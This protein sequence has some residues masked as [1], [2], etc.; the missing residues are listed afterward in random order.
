MTTIAA[1]RSFDVMAVGQVA[2]GAHV[3][4]T[5]GD[6]TWSTSGLFNITALSGPEDLSVNGSNIPVAGTVNAIAA[7]DTN[8]GVLSYTVTGLNT[9]ITSLFDGVGFDPATS[10]ERYW[11]SI[12]AGTTD[13]TA[14]PDGD[15]SMVGDFI[16]VTAGQTVTGAADTFTVNQTFSALVTDLYGDAD[17]VQTAAT[18]TGGNDVINFSNTSGI[19]PHIAGDVRTHAGTVNGGADT[20]NVS[21]F[22]GDGSVI[23]GDAEISDGVLNGGN[24]LMTITASGDPAVDLVLWSGDVEQALRQ[25]NGGDDRMTLNLGQAAPLTLDMELSGDAH[26]CATVNSFVDG[27]NDTITVNDTGVVKIA[28][29][30]I[31]ASNGTVIGGNDTIIINATRAF[32]IAGDIFS[33]TGGTLTPG[34][35]TIRGGSGDDNLFGESTTPFFPT[36]IGTTV[37]AGG[38]DII[39]GRAGN[40]TILGQVGNDILIGG[41]GN[42]SINGGSGID[43]VKFN[44]IAASVFVD[45]LGIPGSGLA[46]AIGQGNDDLILIENVTG[47]TLADTVRGD[48]AANILRGLSGDDLLSGRGGNDLIVGGA[49]QDTLI[50]GAGADVFDFD[51]V[52][53]LAA[54][55]ALTDRIIG[56]DAADRIDLSTIDAN[57]SAAGNQAFTFQTTPLTGAAQVTFSQTG[58]NTVVSGSTD[59]DGVAE[60]VIVLN[61]LHALSAAD[62][63]L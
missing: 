32:T 17:D 51:S 5:S 7:F 27:G 62:F 8:L 48:G 39:D 60:F 26:S 11:E 37:N 53:E 40:D 21:G 43:T 35:D 6:Y 16:R 50:G 25:V 31:S 49:G 23:S 58:G 42:D 47:S 30:V 46:E 2:F 13:F 1:F 61:G 4:H 41:L 52:T 56:F 12:L 14:G 33:F 19:L 24:D 57:G 44:T 34:A 45:L 18:L 59:A 22:F 29:D 15:I 3:F 38:N 20:I 54:T 55:A 10:H 63:I 36:T 9:G 28:G